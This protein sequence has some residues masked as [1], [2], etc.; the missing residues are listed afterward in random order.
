[1]CALRGYQNLWRLF[2]M[3][4]VVFVPVGMFVSDGRIQHHGM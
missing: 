1:V 4:V 2:T 3:R